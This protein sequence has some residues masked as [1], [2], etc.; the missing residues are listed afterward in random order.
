MPRTVSTP[1]GIA[2][3]RNVGVQHREA[4]AT[5]IELVD[6]IEH[7]SGGT[8]QTVQARH[9]QL[10]ARPQKVQN[11]RQLI[12]AFAGG[13]AHFLLADDGAA[14]RLKPLNLALM[15]LV[16]AL[17]VLVGGGDAGIANLRLSLARCVTSGL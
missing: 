15:V 6:D 12:A 8:A 3:G 10:I 9:H 1:P 16:G 5:L 14:L 7:V 13:A 11:G 17:M 4:G 2:L